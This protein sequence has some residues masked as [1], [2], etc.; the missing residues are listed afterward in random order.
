MKSLILTSL[1]L[2]AATLASQA[3]ITV[4]ESFNYAAGAV[5][6]TTATGTG[7]TGNWGS[8]WFNNNVSGTSD[9][10]FAS[11]SLT[12]PSG[13]GYTPSNNR[14]AYDP[15][16]SNNN[17]AA[18]VELATANK[19][20]FGTDG[21]YYVSF[22]IRAFNNSNTRAELNFQTDTGSTL[23]S[24]GETGAGTGQLNLNGTASTR[25]MDTGSP[26][27]IG[28]D[29]LVV[30]R[31]GT[32]AAGNDTLNASF[33]T[34]GVD[35]VSSEP[36]TWDVSSS[37]TSSALASG[38]D[39]RFEDGFANLDV[40]FDELRIGSSFTDVTAVPEPSVFALL[41][42]FLALGVVMARRRLR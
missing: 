41:A 36:I 15:A 32:S 5:G 35:T 28:T 42:G 20:D 3:Q 16:D 1:G 31:I 37:I 2:A 38:L 7:L 12:A 27:A 26:N 22:L 29:N 17:S 13:Y 14:L 10:A 34:S 23:F 21:T 19:I 9:A 11:G 24:I 40:S 39:I 4:T 18:F 33:W 8:F 30:L 25:L 6:N